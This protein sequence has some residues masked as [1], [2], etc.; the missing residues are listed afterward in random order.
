MHQ[1]IGG[2]PMPAYVRRPH[3]EL[4]RA[5]L[6]PAVPASRLVVVR[7]GSST[8][9]TRAAYEA[10]AARLADWH[11]DYPLDPGALA[12]RLETGIPARTVLWLGEL[13][14]YAD[15]DGG[16][17]V[18]AR[19]ADLLNDDG[20]LVIT[21][22]WPEHWTAYTA[23]ARAGLGTADPAGTAGRLLERLPEL[24]GCDP[25]GIE[26]ARGGVIDVP[27]RFTP[28][29]LKAATRTGDSVLAAAAAAAADAGQDGQVTQYLAGVPDLLDRYAGPGG[30]PYGQ[31]IIT[32]A[33]DATRLGHASPLPAS[34]HPRGG[35]RVPD[36]PAAHRAHRQLARHRPGLGRR[37]AQ[38]HHPGPA[39]HSVRIRHWRS[40]I[41]GRRL[42]D[43]ARHPGTPLCPR[44]RQ[45]LG[46]HPQPCP[47]I[48]PM[49][50]GSLTAPA[51]ASCITTPSRY[52]VAPPTPATRPPPDSGQVAGRSRRPGRAAR[53]GR[54][55]R[56]VRR[57]AAG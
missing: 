21:T 13:R 24:A 29:D 14:Q 15:A 7:G 42:P 37:G 1:V 45:H 43:P 4:L 47:A 40:R 5:V 2:G 11:L 56:P 41:P 34:A 55:R 22:L 44:A 3:D 38:R 6:D 39:A 16:P 30:N 18:L 23:A 52:T 10:V 48:P 28:A 9:K 33:M 35:S 12:A 26:P 8:G 53:P 57:L 50:S 31:A 36:R 32:A 51:T 25:A 17:A 49:P 46:R 20:H 54:R 27:D 19:L